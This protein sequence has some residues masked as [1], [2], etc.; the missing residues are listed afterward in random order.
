MPCF[1]PLCSLRGTLAQ[2]QRSIPAAIM[3]IEQGQV[4]WLE[5]VVEG[6]DYLSDLQTRIQSMLDGQPA[7]LLRLRRA[8]SQQSATLQ[9]E[10]STLDELSPYEVFERRL[11]LEEMDDALAADLRQR[12]GQVLTVLQEEQA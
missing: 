6:D 8:R 2:L 7:E 4:L 11:A 9:A 12:Y 3:N 1:Q 5:V 10:R